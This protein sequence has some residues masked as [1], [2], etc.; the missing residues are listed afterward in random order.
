MQ[1]QRQS[2]LEESNG[3]TDEAAVDFDLKAEKNVEDFSGSSFQ[4]NLTEEKGKAAL[5]HSRPH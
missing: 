3:E 1:G 4:E 2:S 5:K